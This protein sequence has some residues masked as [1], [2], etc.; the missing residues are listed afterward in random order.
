ML[1]KHLY[2]KKI[3]KCH[4][5]GSPGRREYPCLPAE[6][7]LG[8]ISEKGP[9]N[10]L[11]QLPQCTDKT[12][13]QGR[14][15]LGCRSEQDGQPELG[16]LSRPRGAQSPKQA[17]HPDRQTHQ[18]RAVSRCLFWPGRAGLGVDSRAMSNAEERAREWAEGAEEGGGRRKRRV[19]VTLA[20]LLGWPFP[21]SRL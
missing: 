11:D 10:E 1:L 2:L 4:R 6:W 12:G 15:D 5:V 20:F 19:R 21:A 17:S 8:H 3:P 18:E 7:W 14:K 9:W 16:P 13:G